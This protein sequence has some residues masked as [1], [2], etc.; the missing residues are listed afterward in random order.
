MD[1]HNNGA[2]QEKPLILK[3]DKRRYDG[4]M[5]IEL[6]EYIEAQRRLKVSQ[7]NPIVPKPA[8]QKEDTTN[9][10]TATVASPTEKRSQKFWTAF[11]V[12]PMEMAIGAV[13]ILTTLLA[14]FTFTQVKNQELLAQSKSVFKD[15]CKTFVQ[16]IGHTLLS[17]GKLVKIAVV[18]S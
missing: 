4:G 15:C 16:G 6:I 9:P 1:Q 7:T 11:L 5:E 2:Q 13:G 14:I 18:G 10:T 12:G 8:D 3:Y 17:P